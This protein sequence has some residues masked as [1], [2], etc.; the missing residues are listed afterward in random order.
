VRS[1]EAGEDR[2]WL[3]ANILPSRAEQSAVG[4]SP[5]WRAEL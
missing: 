1:C 4:P 2:S 5:H 3:R